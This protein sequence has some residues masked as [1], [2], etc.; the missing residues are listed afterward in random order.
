MTLFTR[1]MYGKFNQSSK[2]DRKIMNI[3]VSVKESKKVTEFLC[4]EILELFR[5]FITVY[6]KTTCKMKKV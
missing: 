3:I 1:Y 5:D 2:L 6:R 4:Y